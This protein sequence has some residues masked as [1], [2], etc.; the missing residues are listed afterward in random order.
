MKFCRLL[1]D[2]LSLRTRPLQCLEILELKLAK[3]VIELQCVV[4]FWPGYCTVA[5]TKHNEPIVSSIAEKSKICQG[6]N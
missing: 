3:I 5:L 2:L 1:N 4:Y 6:W